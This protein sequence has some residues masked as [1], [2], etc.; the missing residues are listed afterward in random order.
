METV[1]R[2]SMILLLSIRTALPRQTRSAQDV[3]PTLAGLKDVRPV[4][5]PQILANDH[6][7]IDADG[8]EDVPPMHAPKV[9]GCVLRCYVV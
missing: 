2:P 1:N 7:Y 8:R 6:V 4:L 5:R 9:S 3:D